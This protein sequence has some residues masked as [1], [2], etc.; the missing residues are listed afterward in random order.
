MLRE[1]S[2]FHKCSLSCFSFCLSL[3]R[4]LQPIGNNFL[5]YD[6]SQLLRRKMNFCINFSLCFPARSYLAIMSEPSSPLSDQ[7]LRN[8]FPS[9]LSTIFLQKVQKKLKF[10]K[11]SLSSACLKQKAGR[12]KNSV[13]SF[14]FGQGL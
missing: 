6:F 12:R 2:I 9:A 1:R 4:L 14:Y 3:A 7:Q 11:V 8:L 5:I 10:I 13:K